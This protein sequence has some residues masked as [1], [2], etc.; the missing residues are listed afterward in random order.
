[1]ERDYYNEL[2]IGREAAV[3]RR[4]LA[5]R[6]GMSE[7]QVRHKIAELR[8]IDN[9]DDYII[10]SSSDPR[11]AGYYKSNDPFERRAFIAEVKSRAINTFKPLR[12]ANRIERDSDTR[13]MS[14]ANNLKQRRTMAG[15]KGADM[16]QQLTAAG[17]YMD[18][19][20]L[21]RIE[22]GFVLPTPAMAEKMAEIIGCD[23][24]ELFY[25]EYMEA[26]GNG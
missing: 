17:F 14:L 11:S 2:P 20:L 9:G 12:K 26:A 22:N 21:S 25:A 24:V 18:V 23:T 1:M 13:Q 19:A 6:W 15:I 5:E 10:Y 7:C 3:T 4:E 16:A 8:S